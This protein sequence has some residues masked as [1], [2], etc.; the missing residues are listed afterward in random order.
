M[1]EEVNSLVMRQPLN[2]LPEEGGLEMAK[3]LVQYAVNKS[4]EIGLKGKVMV[5]TMQP[6]IFYK[7]GFLPTHF[8][9][10]AEREELLKSLENGDSNNAEFVIDMYLPENAI[11]KF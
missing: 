8:L 2:F 3:L 5:Y 6:A 11:S 1:R 9:P 4:K 7:L 10:E